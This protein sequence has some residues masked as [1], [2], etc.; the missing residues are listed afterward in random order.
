[1]PTLNYD[2]VRTRDLAGIRE[3][4]VFPYTGPAS[5]ATGGESISASD[6]LLGTIELLPDFHITDGTTVR[7]M[8]YNYTT[9]K[10]V[11]FVPNTNVQ[12]ANGVNL[13]TFTGRF[14]VIGT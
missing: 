6:V 11:A 3:R 12:V 14:E 13:S 10:L 7:T 8:V 4:R 2:A 9:G 1:M 5:Y